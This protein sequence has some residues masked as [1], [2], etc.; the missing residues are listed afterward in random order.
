MNVKEYT[1]QEYLDDTKQHI[2]DVQEL[3]GQF[4]AQ[5]HVRAE[6]HDASKLQCPEKEILR[7][8][9]HE[10]DNCQYEDEAY[11]FH[12]NKVREAVQHHYEHNSH[13]PEHYEEGVSGMN[14]LD[15]VEMFFDWSATAK[16][17]GNKV[18]T[19]IRVGQ[20]RFDMSDELTQ[21]FTNTAKQFN[22]T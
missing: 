7:K 12:L 8:H 17:H 14:L 21:I 1:E 2:H 9:S 11:M 10:L 3:L 19:S 20:E 5:L 4:I 16:K 22:L 13:H 18:E 6:T 15:I